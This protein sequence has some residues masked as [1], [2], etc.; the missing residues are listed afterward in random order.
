MT[1]YNGK[2]QVHTPKMQKKKVIKDLLNQYTKHR[3]AIVTIT[4]NISIKY[5]QKHIY[6]FKNLFIHLKIFLFLF[7]RYKYVFILYENYRMHINM[8]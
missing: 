6:S 7:N 5:K 8:K 3:C 1:F 4:L 2:T